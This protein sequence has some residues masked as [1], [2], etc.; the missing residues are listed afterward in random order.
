MSSQWTRALG[1]L[2]GVVLERSESETAVRAGRKYPA[3]HAR[4]V[5]PC[6][7]R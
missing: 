6:L 3:E 2:A 7:L 4:R 1:Y 5:G